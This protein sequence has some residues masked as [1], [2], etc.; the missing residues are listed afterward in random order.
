MRLH[1]IS[2]VRDFVKRTIFFRKYMRTKTL[3]FCNKI[4][5]FD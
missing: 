1:S 5:H 4:I 2:D 3:S